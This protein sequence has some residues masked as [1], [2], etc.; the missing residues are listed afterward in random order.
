MIITNKLTMDLAKPFG[1]A[2]V[3]AVQDDRYSRN[4]EITLLNC[5]EEWPIPEDACVMIRYAKPDGVG[6]LYDTL[7]DGSTAWSVA[8][9]L[10]TI[11]LA[12]Q[13]LTVPGQVFLAV[14]LNRGI[15]QLST[16]AIVIHVHRAVDMEIGESEPYISVHNFLPAPADGTAGQFLRIAAVDEY[17]HI[18]ALE[19]ADG[20]ST[21][22]TYVETNGVGAQQNPAAP[23][24]PLWQQWDA[25]LAFGM[26][27]AAAPAPFHVGGQLLADGTI[28]ARNSGT[29][30]KNRWGLPRV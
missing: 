1:I 7:P 8:E 17:G 6:G 12:P 4:L 2:A 26:D 23:E 25:R 27:T 19:S 18:S 29:Q 11:A 21:P 30:D 13:V 14:T 10:L 22:E 3:D 16:M 24:N 28:I 15:H 20:T 5:G 9:S